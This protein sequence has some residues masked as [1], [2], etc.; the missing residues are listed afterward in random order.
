MVLGQGH[1]A[2]G[3]SNVQACQVFTRHVSEVPSHSARAGVRACGSGR[4][5]RSGG[6]TSGGLQ[7]PPI[8]STAGRQNAPAVLAHDRT[9]RL[10]LTPPRLLHRLKPPPQTST[11][12]GVS[13]VPNYSGSPGT[14]HSED[15]VHPLA[16]L[17]NSPMEA[18][19]SALC[20]LAQPKLADRT[21]LACFGTSVPRGPVRAAPGMNPLPGGEGMSRCRDD[22]D[23]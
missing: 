20:Q 6:S 14:A 7:D 19:R 8:D 11:G 12:T 23:T 9:D 10:R 15:S 5:D 17:Q 18:A 21:L 4:S 1:P 3:S 13:C 16:S 22:S 2:A